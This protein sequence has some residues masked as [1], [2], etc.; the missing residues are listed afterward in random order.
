MTIIM[1][2]IHIYRLPRADFNYSDVDTHLNWPFT[3]AHNY[4]F[5][6]SPF[7][8]QVLF[9]FDPLYYITWS[10]VDFNFA[11]LDPYC[12]LAVYLG[13]KRLKK[14]KTTIKKC[15]LNPYFN[16]SFSFEV[17]FE[18]IQVFWVNL[19]FWMPLSLLSTVFLSFFA[20]FFYLSLSSFYLCHHRWLN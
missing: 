16:E 13:T 8:P 12:K 7:F 9:I 19:F 5:L 11:A 20:L 4:S 14:K 2:G 10:T 1:I 18:Q 17:T 3:W 15:T 6:S